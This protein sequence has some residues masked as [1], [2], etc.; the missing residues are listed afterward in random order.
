MQFLVTTPAGK[1]LTLEAE[2]TDTILQ[3]KQQIESKENIPCNM[4]CLLLSSCYELKDHWTTC[5]C[6]IDPDSELSL[7]L[8][9]PNCIKLL[10]EV[11]TGETWT[12]H[13]HPSATVKDLKN[14]IAQKDVKI[15]LLEVQLEQLASK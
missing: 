2:P 5:E 14:Q 7:T 6:N 12:F 3:V 11:I 1:T 8:L 4:Q 9:S 10:V 15:R 13:I